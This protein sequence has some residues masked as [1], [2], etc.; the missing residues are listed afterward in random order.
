MDPNFCDR[1]GGGAI[2][3]STSWIVPLSLSLIDVH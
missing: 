2:V 3:Y 1:G